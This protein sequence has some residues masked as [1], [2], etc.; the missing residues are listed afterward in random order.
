MFGP[1]KFIQKIQTKFAKTATKRGKKICPPKHNKMVILSI[2]QKILHNQCQPGF[3]QRFGCY[4]SKN[5]KPAVRL[6]SHDWI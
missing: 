1:N 2:K 5:L 3:E 6:S 4:G